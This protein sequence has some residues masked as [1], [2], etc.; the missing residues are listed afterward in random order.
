MDWFS[1]VARLSYVAC[2]L[3]V[4]EVTS[5]AQ[6]SFAERYLLVA[7]RVMY[8]NHCAHELGLCVPQDYILLEKEIKTSLFGVVVNPPH[9]SRLPK[10]LRRPLFAPPFSFSA[11]AISFS[12]VTL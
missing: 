7:R 6:Q 9:L 5:R 3:V 1:V 2:L 11:A 10:V 8:I 4:V 12:F